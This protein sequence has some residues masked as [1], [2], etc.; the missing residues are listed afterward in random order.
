MKKEKSLNELLQPPRRVR[1]RLAINR[2]LS[3]RWT[4][5]FILAALVCVTIMLGIMS[6]A[7][8]IFRDFLL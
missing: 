1:L 4:A 3:P 5:K 7:I 6:L 8:V 2:I